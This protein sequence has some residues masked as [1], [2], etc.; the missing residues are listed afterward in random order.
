M[1]PRWELQYSSARKSDQER[2]CEALLRAVT[3]H[4][5]LREACE[6]PEV[7]SGPIAAALAQLH[8]LTASLVALFAVLLLAVLCAAAEQCGIVVATVSE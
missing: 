6:S 1:D 3:K 2:F 4:P 5:T 7:R 8:A